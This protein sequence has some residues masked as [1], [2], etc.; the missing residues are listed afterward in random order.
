VPGP[1]TPTERGATR[2]LY[3]RT[4][5]HANFYAYLDFDLNAKTKF[6]TRHCRLNLVMGALCAKMRI[7]L[8]RKRPAPQFLSCRARFEAQL[9]CDLRRQ[10]ANQVPSIRGD[11]PLK[12]DTKQAKRAVEAHFGVASEVRV[13]E[14]LT[15]HRISHTESTRPYLRS[16]RSC[17]HRLSL[18]CGRGV[19]RLICPNASSRRGA[20]QVLRYKLLWRDRNARILSLLIWTYGCW[21]CTQRRLGRGAE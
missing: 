6:T 18:R 4:E 17:F 16:C 2:G 19:S 7:A 3:Y 5:R 1:V 10:H 20:A 9:A 8:A 14:R 12:L 15:L 11:S 13:P 21:Y